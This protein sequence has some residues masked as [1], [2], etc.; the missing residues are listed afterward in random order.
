MGSNPADRDKTT[1]HCKTSEGQTEL[2]RFKVACLGLAGCPSAYQAWLED[3][4]KDCRGTQVYLDDMIHGTKD[5]ES[6]AVLLEQVLLQCRKH[7][8]YLHPGKCEWAVE[9]VDFL[10]MTI[11]YNRISIS[12]EKVEALRVYPVPRN[13]PEVRRFLGFANYVQQF[14]PH[15]STKASALTNM[16]KGQED[17]KKKFVWTHD[18]QF[19]FDSLREALIKSM[20]LVIPDL[21][22]QF[23]IESDASGEGVGAVLFQFVDDRLTPIWF[24]SKKFNQAERNYSPRDREALAIIFALAKFSTYV[25]LKPFVLYS[26]HESLAKFKDQAVLKGRDWRYAEQISGY[27]FEQRYRKGDMMVMPDALSRAFATYH[28]ATGDTG[29]VWQEVIHGKG[30]V[31]SI[32]AP[33]KLTIPLNED[34][35]AISA[36]VHPDLWNTLVGVYATATLTLHKQ[37]E[38]FE[39]D[40]NILREIVPPDPP[41]IVV[42]REDYK[43]AYLLDRWLG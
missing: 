8:I 9:K 17:K 42:L 29:G 22:G 26:D 13:F 4:M 35:T 38:N 20:G 16:L 3:V 14:I 15:F 27:V 18:H 36:I 5:L 19:A 40:N 33:N 25:K 12:A 23:V 21:N 31:I 41:E 1:F 34:A 2:Y 30:T 10:G 6:H 24:S 11:G 43:E 37:S 39:E 7:N 32:T 28:E